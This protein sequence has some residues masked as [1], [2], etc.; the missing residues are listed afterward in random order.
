[1]TGELFISTILDAPLTFA[2]KIDTFVSSTGFSNIA[3]LGVP[4]I[5]SFEAFMCNTFWDG[6][7]GLI[8]TL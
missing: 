2:S 4:T 1:M 6:L 5:D 7:D 8:L 3:A